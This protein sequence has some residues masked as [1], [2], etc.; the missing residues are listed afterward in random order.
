MKSEMNPITLSDM[1]I[2]K[3]LETKGLTAWHLARLCV[4]QILNNWE[5]YDQKAE[6]L[7]CISCF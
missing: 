3:P 6:R 2:N 7:L 5:E 4:G 1:D